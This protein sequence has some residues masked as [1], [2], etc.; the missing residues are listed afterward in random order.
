MKIS[1]LAALAVV[2]LAL[3]VAA[4]DP[5]TRN[6]NPE[7]CRGSIGAVRV[8]K[9]IVPDGATCR[10]NGTRVDGSVEVKRDA[11]LIATSSRVGGN[12]QSQNHREVRVGRNTSI[13][14]HST[15]GGSIQLKQGGFV[16]VNDT[17]VTGDIQYES[18]SGASL[19]ANRNRVNGNIQIVGNRGNNVVRWNT[20]GGNLQ[21]KENA[22]APTGHSNVVHGDKEDQ[23]RT[24]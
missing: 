15:V 7:A 21:C 4:C 19:A 1:R 20:V 11:T 5:S 24:L 8:E 14:V 23:C 2:P 16:S 9:V 6:A 3:G 13:S 12:I 18:N 22:P 17:A 10:L